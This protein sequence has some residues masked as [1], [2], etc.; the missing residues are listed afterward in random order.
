MKMP[1]TVLKAVIRV[2]TFPNVYKYWQVN[3]RNKEKLNMRKRL[4]TQAQNDYIVS[5]K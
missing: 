2:Q 5:S 3:G 4:D 1:V